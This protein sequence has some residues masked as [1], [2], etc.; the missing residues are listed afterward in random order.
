MFRGTDL[1]HGWNETISEMALNAICAVQNAENVS[2]TGTPFRARW[3]AQRSA[4]DAD[5]GFL[6]FSWDAI[7]LNPSGFAGFQHVTYTL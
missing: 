5:E 3:E 2:A 4:A 7:Q 1:W 6:S